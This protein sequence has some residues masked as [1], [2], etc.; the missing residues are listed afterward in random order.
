MLTEYEN[1]YEDAMTEDF[2]R[3][4]NGLTSADKYYKEGYD[5]FANFD[6]VGDEYEIVSSEEE[7]EIQI[8]D[9]IFNGKIDLILKDKEGN[10]II[11]DWKSKDKFKSDSEESIYRRQLYLYS[12]HIHNK[13][14]VYPSKTIFYC[15]RQQVTFEK[16]FDMDAFNEAVDWM[17]NTVDKIRKTF[18]CEYEWYRCNHICNFRHLCL[19]KR[20]VESNKV[21]KDFIK[22]EKKAKV[23]VEV[24]E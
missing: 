20:N 13:Y 1:G 22:K 3:L 5:F 8:Q 4:R 23:K 19:L 24:I 10:Y 6:G 14:S 16:P 7:F 12:L 2:P 15:F 18:Y 17:I 21:L 9:F 11:W